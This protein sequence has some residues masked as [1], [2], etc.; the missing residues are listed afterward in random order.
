MVSVRINCEMTHRDKELIVL[1]HLRQ[2]ETALD[3]RQVSVANN[4]KKKVWRKNE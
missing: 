4:G 3:K 1:W 2:N